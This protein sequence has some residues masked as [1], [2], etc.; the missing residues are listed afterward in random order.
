MSATGFSAAR[1]RTLDSRLGVVDPSTLNGV[2]AADGESID[3]TG[4]PLPLHL[5]PDTAEVTPDGRLSIGGVDVVSITEAVGTPVFIY[6]EAHL[7]S[8]CR[9]ARRAFGDGVA[10]ASKAFLC[11]AMATL[12]RQEGMMI[13]VASGG[14]LFVALRAGVPAERLVL[15][16]NNK[17]TE[18][19]ALAISVG[20]GRIVVDSFDEI[21]RLEL[22][23]GRVKPATTPRVLVRVN[24][25]VS[26]CTHASVATGQEDSKFGFSLASGAAAE[27][28]VSLAR[29]RNPV[30]LVGL[31]TH[32][33]SQIFD[34]SAF[35][36]AISALAPLLLKSDLKELSVGGGLG[37]TYTGG[38]EKAPSLAAWGLA[39]RE[40]CRVA[41]ISG[42][43]R[44]TAEPGRAIAATAAVTCYRI[45]AI[46]SIT[47]ES[48]ERV[49]T[50]V[51]VD[52]GMSDNLR[53]ALYDSRYEAFL[54]REVT[55][56]RPLAVTVAGKHCESGD[57]L[58]QN[59]RL[60]EDA[61]V[62]DVLA[63]PVTGAYGYAMASNYNKLLRPPIV[64]VRD[65][66]YRVVTRRETDEDLLR[67]DVD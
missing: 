4:V 53:P 17:S 1:W 11:R 39:V 19:L 13:D 35:G 5:L 48:P 16:G 7:R 15:H 62:G 8:R 24:P 46:K 51:S 47:L 63:T 27:A 56:L 9:E 30:D 25:G 37:V 26:V 21:Q 41:G 49:R 10:Y 59:G 3:R 23:V 34:L 61:V 2:R 54:P 22:L 50:Y 43:V 60:P 29:Q 14:E 33:G 40:A 58:V 28:V 52:G 6:D 18:E 44:V 45:G 57:V 65:G 12:L 36:Q 55:A 67:L 31:H 32:I 64:F 38:D 42:S 66:S 20:I